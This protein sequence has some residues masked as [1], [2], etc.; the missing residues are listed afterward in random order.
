MPAIAFD[1]FV[2]PVALH[3]RPDRRSRRAGSTGRGRPPPSNATV[4]A[5][6]QAADIQHRRAGQGGPVDLGDAEEDRCGRPSGWRCWLRRDRAV[7]LG[8]DDAA[9]AHHRDPVGGR[10]HLAELV[11]DEDR[12]IGRSRRSERMVANSSSRVSCGRQ[13]GGRLVEDEHFGLS[14]ERLQDL[15]ALTQADRQIAHARRADRGRGRI[16]RLS[17]AVSPFGGSTLIETTAID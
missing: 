17:S 12:P 8:R 16:Y 3:A 10:Q 13:H 4:A 14:V 11:G 1:Q 7:V 5:D 6:R 15:H 9:L 2:L